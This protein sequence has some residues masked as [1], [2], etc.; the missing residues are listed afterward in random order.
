MPPPPPRRRPVPL[1]VRPEQRQA[2]RRSVPRDVAGFRPRRDSPRTRLVD[3]ARGTQPVRIMV[4]GPA[5]PKT[6]RGV[7]DALSFYEGRQIPYMEML[8]LGEPS[9]EALLAREL[10]KVGAVTAF[11]ALSGVIGAGGVLWRSPEPVEREQL[12]E[13]R[14]RAGSRRQRE[15]RPDAVVRLDTAASRS[16]ISKQF[17]SN[18]SAPELAPV[19]GDLQ[20]LDRLR[21]DRRPRRL[22]A[23]GWIHAEPLRRDREPILHID[24][25]CPELP[26]PGMVTASR[27]TPPRAPRSL[28]CVRRSPSPRWSSP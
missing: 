12:P 15:R 6:L 4:T 19:R 1:P 23:A 7:L 18:A 28:R 9:H 8:Y 14:R 10:S 27:S 3:G 25:V 13:H 22:G 24:H 26:P 17:P 16:T 5:G 20:D 21:F 2:C 11:R